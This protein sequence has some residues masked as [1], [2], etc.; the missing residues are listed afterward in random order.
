M[1]A[2]KTFLYL[3][4]VW[5]NLTPLNDEETVW[6]AVNSV[7]KK[8]GVKK[9]VDNDKVTLCGRLA[10][11]T[12]RH[13]EKILSVAKGESLG[14][15]ITEYI[16]G[17][18]MDEVLKSRGCFSAP[19]AVD[20]LN[21]ILSG[22][23]TLHENNVIHRDIKPENIIIS[24]DGIVKIIDYGIARTKKEG[25]SSDTTVLGTIGYAAPEQF[26]FSQT[27]EKTD[28]YALG[29]LFNVM[30]TGHI[31]K[32]GVTKEKAYA[33]IIKKCT[34]IKPEE[35]YRSVSEL[36]AAINGDSLYVKKKH[37]GNPLWWLPGFRSLT[38]WKM[39]LGGVVYLVMILWTILCF[40]DVGGSIFQIFLSS[41]FIIFHA[42]AVPLLAGNIAYWDRHVKSLE[43]WTA[44]QRRALR[45]TWGA[46][47][48]LLGFSL[49]LYSIG[50]LFS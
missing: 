17:E 43:K 11:L 18:T 12:D 41:V 29:V 27:D 14:L 24:S 8:V 16:S 45:L 6:L 21:D 9:Y 34:D 22:V 15:I 40:E 7:T 2:F 32:D 39:L 33:D 28:I 1:N 30:L 10:G 36:R 42:V 5:Q 20:I 26:G 13:L 3:D 25:K 37:S 31:P 35:R 19:E 23:E 48:W 46:I 50:Q 4:E 44:L 49:Y 47:L 38:W